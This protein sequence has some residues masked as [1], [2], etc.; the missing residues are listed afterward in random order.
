MEGL[1]PIDMI[2]LQAMVA[3]WAISLASA[4]YTNAT[5][6]ALANVE[7]G[8]CDDC[9]EVLGSDWW[10]L[11]MDKDTNTVEMDHPE[12][13]YWTKGCWQGT[14]VT[15]QTAVG[16]IFQVK[17]ITGNCEL[18]RMGSGEAECTGSELWP[19]TSEN[20]A[21]EGAWYFAVNGTEIDEVECKARL[22][23]GSTTLTG[24]YPRTGPVDI[25]GG[26]MSGFFCTGYM[27]IHVAWVVF[28][29]TTPP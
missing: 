21:E 15:G 7:A 9:D 12:G 6:W 10:A 13:N 16:V 18:K 5:A 23:P 22:A 24:I 29:G 11:Y 14:V 20:L 1:S 25:N 3:P 26:F 2:L 8:Y 27:E 17:N 4:A 28:E 19:N